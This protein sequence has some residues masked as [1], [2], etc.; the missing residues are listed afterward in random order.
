MSTFQTLLN[1][2]IKKTSSLVC[3]GLDSEVKKIPL[4]LKVKKDIQFEF[5]K[6]IIDATSDV[7]CA[8]KPNIA[9]Y[10]AEGLDG[11][12]QLKKTIEYLKNKY[13]DIPVILDAKRADIGNT[14]KGYVK[15]A[16][17][18]LGADAITIHPYMGKESIVP[19]LERIDKGIFILCRT[20][21][22]GAGEFQDII[23]VNKPLYQIVA[24]NVSHKWNGN[25][26]CGLVVGATYPSELN[27]VRQIAGE[28]PILIPGV[29]A[30]GA[31][32]E[33]TIKAG[34]GKDGLN[35]IINSSRAI[36][37]ADDSEH[38]TQIAREKTLELRDLINKN[39]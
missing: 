23:S 27:I 16:F 13:L 36:I 25:G 29:G 2:R 20:S 6:A 12:Q 9:F 3:I 32:V 38:F 18:Y 21:N 28:I 5:N 8:Y 11:L 37:F 10:E 14:N 1:N 26:N 15:F 30:Q 31:D 22:P 17:D 34:I 33:K 24:D 39:I 19:F 7:V 35:T 4:H